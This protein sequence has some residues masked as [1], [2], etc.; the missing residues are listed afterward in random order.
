MNSP[1]PDAV[2]DS[3]YERENSRRW[4]AQNA[5]DPFE[6][7]LIEASAHLTAAFNHLSRATDQVVKAADELSGTPMEDDMN[8]LIG[9]MEDVSAE[10]CS[11][12]SR[13]DRYYIE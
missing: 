3:M 11:F 12:R 10:I 2:L 6:G 4:E 13:Y 8:Y 1:T 9:K 7:L 5:P